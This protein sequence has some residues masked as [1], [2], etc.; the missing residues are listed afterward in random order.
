MDMIIIKAEAPNYT[1]QETTLIHLQMEVTTA[2]CR[3]ATEGMLFKMVGETILLASWVAP[4]RE[5]ILVWT[6]AP[7]V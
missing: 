7:G 6:P 3:R 4:V 5:E 1:N 2:K